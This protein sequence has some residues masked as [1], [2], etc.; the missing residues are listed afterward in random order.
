MQLIVGL[1]NPGPEYELTPHNLGF[2]LIDRLAAKHGIRVTR[3]EC[4]ALVGLGRIGGEEVI[5]AKP[6][7]YMNLSGGPVKMLLSKYGLGPDRLLAVYDELDL[8][9]GGMKMRPRGSAAGH[10]GAASIISS[11]Q[12]DVF[13]RLRL[14]I[15][16]GRPF[17][18][19]ASYVLRP[20]RKEELDELELILERAA[21]VAELYLAEGADK[22]MAVANRRA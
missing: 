7:S 14:G 17:G 15:H 2:L 11:L 19:G 20:F 12:T 4:N 10:N 3:P 21:E 9:W 22:A 18:S 5:L 13:W 6:L 8:P 16:P 1:G